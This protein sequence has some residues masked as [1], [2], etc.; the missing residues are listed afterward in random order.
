VL[1]SAAN[2][3]AALPALPKAGTLKHAGNTAA[4]GKRQ[5]ESNREKRMIDKKEH[6]PELER[7]AI[8]AREDR[9]FAR[10]NAKLLEQVVR[11]ERA[12][13]FL[14]WYLKEPRLVNH[15]LVEALLNDV[16]EQSL[17]IAR[18]V[19][20]VCPKVIDDRLHWYWDHDCAD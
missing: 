14:S 8:I 13:E 4:F 18:Q 16:D 7:A 11:I 20:P 6:N 17:R 15:V 19:L 3:V 2:L 12:K 10:K 9:K 5:A 1:P